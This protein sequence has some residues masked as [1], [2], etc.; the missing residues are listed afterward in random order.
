MFMNQVSEAKLTLLLTYIKSAFIH[1][2]FLKTK[3]IYF[4]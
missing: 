2:L 1:W 4:I 3:F